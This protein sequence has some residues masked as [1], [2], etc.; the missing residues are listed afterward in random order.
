MMNLKRL[1]TS[2]KLA[3][4]IIPV[5]MG[6]ETVSYNY[7][8]VYA[9]QEQGSTM[10]KHTENEG[11]DIVGPYVVEGIG[12]VRWNA[13]SFLDVSPKGDQFAYNFANQNT[14]NVF[15][16]SATG[17]SST[18]QRT[19]R[20][21]VNDFAFSKK[22]DKLAFSD[23]V[24]GNLNIFLVDVNSGFAAEQ[25]AATSSDEVNPVFSHD[26]KKLFFTKVETGGDEFAMVTTS[27]IWSVDLATSITTN[28]TEGFNPEP[29][30]DGKVLYFARN[31]KKTGFGEI[32]SVNLTS[33]S[34]TQI[35]A[36]SNKGF[37]N[38]KVS[39][40]GEW[41]AVT[42]VSL[43]TANTPTNLDI[44]LFKTDGSGETQ[45]TFY[46][47]TDVCPVWTPDGKKLFFLSERGNGRKGK[48]MRYNVWS[49]DVSRIVN[50]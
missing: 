8:I 6:C 43:P 29:S 47:G 11:Y 33:G 25:L 20:T 30:P 7:S 9:P 45:L 38:V 18:I 44:Y 23:R 10:Q 17:G 13:S 46:G 36:S 37:A 2:A 31:N 5:F 26:D 34:E 16:R 42:G 24:G 4:G 32:W 15:L 49:I 39:P 1:T 35:I 3:L 27:S 22:G 41:L 21:A 28:Y 19:F 50:R 12:S 14:F 48:S 40:N